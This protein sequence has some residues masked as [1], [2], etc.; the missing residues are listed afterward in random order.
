M[1]CYI[2]RCSV[3]RGAKELIRGLFYYKKK[4]E[5]KE[6]KDCMQERPPPARLL[7]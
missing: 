2:S 6:G 3:A 1:H 5:L 7:S 4:G